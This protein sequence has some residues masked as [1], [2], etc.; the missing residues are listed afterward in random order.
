MQNI[1]V[2]ADDLTCAGEIAGI[3]QRYGLRTRLVRGQLAAAE[4]GATVVDT[5]T[6]LMTPSDASE[7]SRRFVRKIPPS[8]FELI[9]KKVDSAL[10]GQ[11]LA[12]LEALMA[13]FDMPASLM[14]A[15]NP[16]RGRTIRAGEYR[17]NGA[18]LQT[19]PFGNDPDYPARSANVLQILGSSP[20]ARIGCLDPGS[21]PTASG[22][23]VGAA[24][25]ANDVRYWSGCI[26][27]H[28][29]PAGGADFFQA[30]LESNGLATKHSFMRQLPAGKTLF[31]CGSVSTYNNDLAARADKEHVVLC[32]MPNKLFK[33]SATAEM[34]AWADGICDALTSTSRALMF[35][36]QKLD[37]SPGAGQR[38]QN[39]LAST[40]AAVLGRAKVTN[41]MLEGG[42]TA[43]AV[44][45]KMNWNDFEIRGELAPGVVQMRTSLGPEPLVM[46]KPGSYLWP[47]AV[48]R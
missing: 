10:R 17:I 31:I 35:I 38:I 24:S 4:P 21:E 1:L 15:E 14:V 33:G 41:V 40:V 6:R 28:L 2:I 43:A 27:R 11:I 22:I 8:H 23:T 25:T 34:H 32:P 26:H 9:Y 39:A 30:I 18:L 12:E 47:D 29:L 48:W 16:S 46:V 5:D 19:T 37:R 44:C 45:R 42:A 7:T 36:P 3:A 20:Y 13:A